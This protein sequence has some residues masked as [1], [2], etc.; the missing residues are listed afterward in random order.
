LTE[1]LSSKLIG[2]IEGCSRL[3]AV[4]FLL[5]VLRRHNGRLA[6]EI[7][8][9][10]SSISE[11]MNSLARE[12][13][14]IRLGLT[15]ETLAQIDRDATDRFI[16]S[17]DTEKW[18][19]VVQNVK[20]LRALAVLIRGLSH[21]SK[22]PDTLIRRIFQ[23]KLDVWAVLMG[24]ATRTRAARD[25]A[26][27]SRVIATSCPLS[28]ETRNMLLR[29]V[30]PQQFIASV[31]DEQD[32]R[33]VGTALR[34]FG[35]A[36]PNEAES[37]ADELGTRPEPKQWLD[38]DDPSSLAF[39]LFSAAELSGPLATRL[40]E[41]LSITRMR[42]LLEQETK[43][44]RVAE[45]LGALS[46]MGP[47]NGRDLVKQLF[48]KAD[49]HS[50]I[51]DSGSLRELTIL[52]G[53]IRRISYPFFLAWI[54]KVVAK[55]SRHSAAVREEL[56][57]RCREESNLG[58]LA[59]FLALIS[60]L[61]REHELARDIFT[62][63]DY[64]W[65]KKVA[66][67]DNPITQ[68]LQ[69]ITSVSRISSEEAWQRRIGSLLSDE[70]LDRLVEVRSPRAVSA[71][72]VE[73]L[74]CSSL[75]HDPE[76]KSRG[77]RRLRGDYI[78]GL[79]EYSNDPVGC[80]L[81][82]CILREFGLNPMTQRLTEAGLH[83]IPKRLAMYRARNA[84]AAYALLGIR[85]GALNDARSISEMARDLQLW[86]IGFLNWLWLWRLGHSA[87]SRTN[88]LIEP[89]EALH[90]HALERESSVVLLDEAGKTPDNLRFAFLLAFALQ[91]AARRSSGEL[92][93]VLN[94]LQEQAE[95]R[96]K[97]EARTRVRLMLTDSISR[98]DPQ[99]PVGVDVIFTIVRDLCP[100]AEEGGGPEDVIAVSDEQIQALSVT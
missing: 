22:D 38:S 29:W 8:Q 82:A 6:R 40:L 9:E 70:V 33:Q 78:M 86:E 99:A 66:L 36:F 25:L 45:L 80:A 48:G 21:A 5:A 15:L 87:P 81:L 2:L 27:Y 53:A 54:G 68:V 26:A 73:L 17:L 79:F 98:S 39:L 74:R 37:F 76:L 84:L 43:V 1:Q 52:L 67:W 34:A 100:R 16:G 14:P 13:S 10:V 96:A 30:E 58:V 19:E 97:W 42:N 24:L 4:G 90:G 92:R 28:W 59:T 61:E 56:K 49:A 83:D 47:E 18:I 32:P 7:L 77:F 60:S 41:D 89:E 44:T 75:L 69:F 20:N 31:L 62:T 94:F 95:E 72:L 57:A 91:L 12:Y 46:L 3:A 71:C 85:G 63:L 51:Q 64:N 50:V 23:D 11:V 93:S 65:I 55:D 35:V 88:L